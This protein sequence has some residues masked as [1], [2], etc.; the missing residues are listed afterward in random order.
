MQNAA[1][2]TKL[3]YI[4]VWQDSDTDYNTLDAI[5]LNALRIAHGYSLVNHPKLV[6]LL[7]EKDIAVEISPI[8]N[9]ASHQSGNHGNTE[10]M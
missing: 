9:Q 7:K 2:L 4:Q 3:F 1:K 10:C 5:L 6:Q 8:S